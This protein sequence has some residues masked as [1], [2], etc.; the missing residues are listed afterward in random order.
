MKKAFS[1]IL[2]SFLILIGVAR[3]ELISA[4]PDKSNGSNDCT[5]SHYGGDWMA[6]P[7]YL[8][9][10]GTPI[11][12]WV[13]TWFHCVCHYINGQQTFM[14]MRWR[15]T[16][17]YNG[18]DYELNDMVFWNKEKGMDWNDPLYNTLR[19]VSNVKGSDR[20]HLIASGVFT[21]YDENWDWVGIF[22]Y[23]NIVSN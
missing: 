10:S 11:E 8:D 13:Y 17:T 7:L 18:V 3:S 5:I 2:V 4:Q 15:G 9:E 20:S 1:F 14:N 19:F 22:D 16:W 12:V 21:M 6:V 23:D